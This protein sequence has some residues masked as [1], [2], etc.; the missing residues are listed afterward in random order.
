MTKAFSLGDRVVIAEDSY[1]AKEALG[2]VSEPPPEV[3]S[4]SVPWNGLTRGQTT[5]LDREAVYWV[6][7]DEPQRDADGDGPYRGGSIDVNALSLLPKK[8]N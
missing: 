6:W 2:T 5:A 1:W 7:F 4:T 8:S 3:I